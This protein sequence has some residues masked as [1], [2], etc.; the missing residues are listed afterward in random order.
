MLCI[1]RRI[2]RVPIITFVGPAGRQIYKQRMPTRLIGIV[3]LFDSKR[4]PNIS[5]VTHSLRTDEQKGLMYPKVPTSAVPVHRQLEILHP[6]LPQ[7][8]YFN[9][10]KKKLLGFFSLKRSTVFVRLS[11]S[12]E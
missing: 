12:L 10:T 8:R 9:M 11:A 2:L 4:R 5:R 3:Y 1:F 7:V 6:C